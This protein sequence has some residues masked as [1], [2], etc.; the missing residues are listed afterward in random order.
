VSSNDLLIETANVSKI[1]CRNLKRSM[2]YGAGDI[3]RELLGR[4]RPRSLL[5]KDEFWALKDISFSLRRGE[6][7]G[8]IGANGSGKT[9][10]LKIINGLIKPDQGCVTVRG[11]IGA[12]IAL[13]AG[14]NPILTGRENIYI[15][16]AV[17]GMTKSQIDR[18]IDRIVD[19][20]ELHEAIDAPVRTYSSGM[21]VR[22]GFAIYTAL[23]TDVLLI[24]EVLAVGDVAFRS[25]C[26]SAIGEMLKSTAA[27]LVSHNAEALL[28]ICNKGLVLDKGRLI[29]AGDICAALNA[30]E[31]EIGKRFSTQDYLRHCRPCTGY[32]VSL[33]RRHV[34][35]GEQLP[36]D[37]DLEFSEPTGNVYQRVCVHNRQGK[38]IGEWNNSPAPQRLSFP[39]GPSRVCVVLE[40]ILFRPGKYVLSVM[41]HGEGGKTILGH[42]HQVG[43]FHVEGDLSVKC[44]FALPAHLEAA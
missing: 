13:G 33:P 5:R 12:L 42:A 3:A 29:Y 36:V 34:C 1:F 27:I 43:T 17:L 25:K 14:F 30:Y 22:L 4:R 18:Q 39:R 6:C 9:T 40:R 8:L 41:M 44:E 31:N 38:L 20:A 16:G 35:H 28:R 19:F 23:H 15:N 32:R 10:M 24:D 26:Y 21:Y 11:R 7:L 2:R 37:L